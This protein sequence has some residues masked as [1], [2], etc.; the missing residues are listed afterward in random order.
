MPGNLPALQERRP[1]PGSAPDFFEINFRS[2]RPIWP[3]GGDEEMNLWVGF[4][5]AFEPPPG[6]HVYLRMTGCTFY[7]VYLNGKF[8]GW[9]PGRAPLNYAR[10]DLW[11]ITHLLEPGKNFVAVEVAGY[12]VNAFYVMNE[13]SFIQAEV[14]TDSEVLAS[15]G[16]DGSGLK[17]N[18]FPN[19]LR[20]FS[21]TP[22]SALLRGLP[23]G[24]GFE[25]LARARRH[26]D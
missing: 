20:K 2:A 6:K 17:P 23:H 7:H 10:V 5:A 4:R 22:F 19:T 3:E 13:P 24:G 1:G 26:S 18:F 8:H 14:V 11:D 9:G 25:R 15:T 16:G 12:N 21:A